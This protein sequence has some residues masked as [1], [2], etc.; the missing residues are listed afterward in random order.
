VAEASKKLVAYA[1][2]HTSK[3]VAFD[4]VEHAKGLPDWYPLPTWA[5]PE[6]QS[7]MQLLWIERPGADD[8]D[9]WLAFPKC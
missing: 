3:V 7:R 2:A 4:P 6:V 1:L 8:L 5:S 9:G